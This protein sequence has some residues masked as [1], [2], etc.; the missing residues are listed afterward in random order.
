MKSILKSILNSKKA[1]NEMNSIS[2]IRPY[3]YHDSW[4]FDDESKNLHREAFVSGADDMLDVLTA[5]HPKAKNGFNLYFSEFEFPGY[6][7]KLTWDREEMQ[8]NIYR[9]EDQDIEGW[10]CPS[11]LLYFSKA[12]KN[13][14]IKAKL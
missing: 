11:L 6:Q 13:I 3:K 4:V 1:S 5:D 8:G 9:W 2:V 7:I 12:P 14:Y 10:L